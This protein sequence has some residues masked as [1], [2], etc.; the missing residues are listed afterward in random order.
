MSIRIVR[1]KLTED[2]KQRGV[3]YSSTLSTERT[4]QSKDTIHEVFD[5]SEESNEKIERLENTKF[6]RNSHFKYNIIRQS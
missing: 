2:Q 6:F 3:V 1:K 4:E 5:F